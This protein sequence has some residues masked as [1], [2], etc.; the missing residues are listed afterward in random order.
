MKIRLCAVMLL[1]ALVMTAFAG[2]QSG[3]AGQKLDHLEDTI[4]NG[5]EA[6]KETVENALTPSSTHATTATAA[7]AKLTHE[8]AEAIALK[9]AG[10]TAEQVTGLHSNY[11]VEHGVG[12]Y[13]V[14]FH[15]DGWE[16]DYEIHAETGEILFKDKERAD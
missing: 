15:H 9:D 11:D 7:A 13:D 6:V 16:Y 4:E 10:L 14:E 5:L 1:A 8:E 12:E 3:T 2:C